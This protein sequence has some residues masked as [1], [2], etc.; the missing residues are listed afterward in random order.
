MVIDR[1]QLLGGMLTAFMAAEAGAAAPGGRLFLSCRMDAENNASVACFDRTGRELFAAALPARGHDVTVR[2]GAAEIVVFARR[3]GNWFAVLDSADG[4]VLHLVRAAEGR[5]FYGH[6]AF[7]ADGRL[8][9]A[10]ENLMATGDGLIGIYD[11]GAGYRRIGEMASGGIGPHDVMLLPG[12]QGLV[13]ANGG[14]R[15]HPATGRE[16]LNPGDMK[17]NLA[18]LDLAHGEVTARHELGAEMQKLSIRHLAVRRD[19]VVA[20]GCQYQGSPEDAPPL[21]G[22]LRPGSTPAMLEIDEDVLFRM[23]NYIGSVTFDDDGRYLVATS[24]E[25][26]SALVWDIAAERVAQSHRLTDV[27]GAAASAPGAFILTSGNAGLSLLDPGGL[28]PILSEQRWVW[29]NHAR[30]LLRA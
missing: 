26:G 20:F 21:L 27:C 16:I 18:L 7:S 10:T 19:G 15:T 14:L 29:D 12:G 3:P 30:S 17:P 22:L 11:A 1:R 6:G 25:G 8:L 2:P 28:V 9:Y 13:I 23:K 4:A 24:P 5:H